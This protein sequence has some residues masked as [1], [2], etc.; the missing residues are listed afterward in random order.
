[1]NVYE[2]NE[3]GRRA[4]NAVVRRHRGGRLADV[5]ELEEPSVFDP[6][7][8]QDRLRYRLGLPHPAT[9]TGSFTRSVVG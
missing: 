2:A 8:Q 3:A 4:A 9:V 7:K 1:M 6:F 5:W